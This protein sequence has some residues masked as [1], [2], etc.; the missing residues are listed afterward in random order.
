[1]SSFFICLRDET[2]EFLLWSKGNC[3]VS[4]E[5]VVEE[6]EEEEEEDEDDDDDDDDDG[7]D[8]DEEIEE[9]GGGGG[10]GEDRK[11]LSVWSVDGVCSSIAP[12]ASRELVLADFTMYRHR[13]RRQWRRWLTKRQLRTTASTASSATPKE[14]PPPCF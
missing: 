4:Y 3:S 5:E 11:G 7:D 10:G 2:F 9:K 1:M 14:K 13:F 12:Y 6:E 8:N